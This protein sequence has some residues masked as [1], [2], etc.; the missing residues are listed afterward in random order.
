VSIDN[1]RV[2]V[3]RRYHE[4]Y[5]QLVGQVTHYPKIFNQH[6]DVF[7]L[8]ACLGFRH[9]RNPNNKG[10]DLFWS[11]SFNA[12]QETVLTAI[13]VRNANFDYTLME[14]PEEIIRIA[15]SYADGGMELLLESV[16][17]DFIR[18]DDTGGLSLDYHE[19]SLLEKSLLVYVQSE[20]N[21]A[22]V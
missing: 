20:L 8:C 6:A 1:I 4:I 14:R 16:L 19:S 10:A 15:E 3:H 21:R 5:R 7:T 22:P 17:G 2:E 11:H 13:A 12:E 18:K 9:G